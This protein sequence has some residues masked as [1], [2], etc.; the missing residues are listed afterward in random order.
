MTQVPTTGWSARQD[1]STDLSEAPVRNA[2][3]IDCGSIDHVF[4]HF[5]LRLRVYRAIGAMEPAS[6][7]WWSPPE[8][9]AGEAL[10]TVMKKVLGRALKH[11]SENDL[12]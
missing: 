10:P 9:I 12:N 1:G 3:W 8:T 6:N 5:Q 11:E 4:T 7:Q 2:G